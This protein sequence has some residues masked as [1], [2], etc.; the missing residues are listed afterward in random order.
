MTQSIRI[1]ALAVLLVCVTSAAQQLP[2]RDRFGFELALPGWSYEF[3]RDHGSHESF[4]T[5]WWYY[6][7]HL[8][9]ASGRLYGFEVTF[10]RVGVVPPESRT[11]KTRW[12]LGDVSLAH[13]AITDVAGR[14]F[15]Y[16]EKLN[17]SSPYTANA[18]PGSLAVFNEGWSVAMNADGSF[19]LRASSNGDSIDLRL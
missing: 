14:K 11:G 16:Y 15:R 5:E 13:F 3:P 19:R 17:R 12:E 10:F 6:T 9:S 8:T 2:E 18:R 1:F 7:G 4:R